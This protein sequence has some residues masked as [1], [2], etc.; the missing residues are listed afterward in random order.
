MKTQELFDKYVKSEEV[1]NHCLEVS[2]VMRFLARELGENEEE[3]ASAGLLHDIDCDITP[4]ISIQGKKAAEIAKENGY[5]EEVCHAIL[6][7][8]EENLGVKRESK[9]DYLLSAADNVSGLIYSYGLMRKSLDGMDAAGLKKKLK[10]KAFAASVRRDLI[11]DSEKF[12]PLDKFLEIAIKA[13][14]SIKGEI[15]F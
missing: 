8:N 12:I 14:Q 1:K 15:G 5:S 3:W 4:D 9:F 13:M 11:Q 2:T 10:N 7:H 6:S